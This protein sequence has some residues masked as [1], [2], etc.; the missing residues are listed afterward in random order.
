[1]KKDR[2]GRYLPIITAATAMAIY[3]A[4]PM[5]PETNLVLSAV[6]EKSKDPAP[7]AAAKTYAELFS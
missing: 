2:F 1:M 4:R 7:R 3:P 5:A 6:T